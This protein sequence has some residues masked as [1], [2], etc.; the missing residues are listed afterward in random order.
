MFGRV[1]RLSALS[2]LCL[3]LVACGGGATDPDAPANAASS[4]PAYEMSDIVDDALVNI[5]VIGVENGVANG[6]FDVQPLT[7]D[8]T[9][10]ETTRELMTALAAEFGEVLPFLTDADVSE[11][12][13][14]IIRITNLD[15]YNVGDGF[16]DVADARLVATDGD[17][18][19]VSLETR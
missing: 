4:G 13:L 8:T 9:T 14:R 1:E 11:V 17:W 10:L 19:L 12:E 3:V 15:E 7:G 2:G 18:E 5:Q 16:E 6:Y